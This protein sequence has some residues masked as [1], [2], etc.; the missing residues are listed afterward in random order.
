MDIYISFTHNYQKL[1]ANKM[2][3]SRWMDKYTVVHPD[4]E[5]LFSIKNKWA[6]KPWKDTENP[7]MHVA[8][9]KKPIWEG[10]RLFDSNYVKFWK[11]KTMKTVEKISNAK[12]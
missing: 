5:I 12:S 9:W 2:S 6:I 3:V 11:G 7:K 4:N 1:E 8:K 10:Y